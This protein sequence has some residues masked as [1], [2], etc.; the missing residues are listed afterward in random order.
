VVLIEPG[1]PVLPRLW[2]DVETVC[3]PFR[4][5]GA[6]YPQRYSGLEWPDAATLQRLAETTEP[7]AWLAAPAG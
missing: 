4:A 6:T 3:G 2:K 1:A 5:E 7:P